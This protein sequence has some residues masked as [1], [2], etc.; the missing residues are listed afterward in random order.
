MAVPIN[1]FPPD[2]PARATL[3]SISGV[4][5]RG[6]TWAPQ[7]DNCLTRGP[8]SLLVNF[9]LRNENYILPVSHDMVL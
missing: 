4:G 8:V 5:D 1:R 9:E 6:E 2:I 7:V 3:T